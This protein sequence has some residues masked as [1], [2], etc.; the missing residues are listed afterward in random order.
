[1]AYAA[2]GEDWGGNPGD[3]GKTD[4]GAKPPAVSSLGSLRHCVRGAEWCESHQQ[5]SGEVRRPSALGEDLSP[6]DTGKW[7]ENKLTT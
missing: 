4:L 3:G 6:R 5:A 1:M 2:S 7:R